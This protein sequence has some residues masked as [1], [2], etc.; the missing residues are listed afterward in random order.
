MKERNANNTWQNGGA[1]PAKLHRMGIMPKMLM[2]KTKWCLQQILR[3]GKTEF[4][5]TTS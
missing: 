5:S 2:T 3:V 4:K 1:I